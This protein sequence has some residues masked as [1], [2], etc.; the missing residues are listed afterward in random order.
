MSANGGWGSQCNS[1]YLLGLSGKCLTAPC[2]EDSQPKILLTKSVPISL[3]TYPEYSQF[4]KN[5]LS[6]ALAMQF[7]E[8]A[9]DVVVF[10]RFRERNIQFS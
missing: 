3:L 1:V 9:A 10:F 4:H 8:V 5:R 2:R 6:P 7:G